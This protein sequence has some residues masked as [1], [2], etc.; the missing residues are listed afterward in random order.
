MERIQANELATLIFGI[1]C[2]AIVLYILL[3][4][5]LPRFGLFFLGF[6]FLLSANF[7][8]VVEGFLWNTFSN[9][10]EHLSYLFAGT[11]FAAA[12]WKTRR[13]RDFIGDDHGNRRVP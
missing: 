1:V 3:R 4:E 10:L 11:S 8:T 7:F 13:D 12:A 2:A 6:A 5:K 9:F